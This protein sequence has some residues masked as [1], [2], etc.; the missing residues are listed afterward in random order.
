MILSQVAP[1]LYTA[2]SDDCGPSAPLPGARFLIAYQYL[3]PFA[4]QN[5]ARAA[6]KKTSRLSAVGGYRTAA[7]EI[8]VSLSLVR[9]S[10]V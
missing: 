10:L 2:M 7:V 9:L 3:L 6:W 8:P 4:L 1:G 5:Y